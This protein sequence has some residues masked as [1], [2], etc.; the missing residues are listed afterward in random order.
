M[1]EVQ[2]ISM[3][4]KTEAQYALVLAQTGDLALIGAQIGRMVET[5]SSNMILCMY[6]I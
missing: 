2:G 6:I 1:M 3:D 5:G 4:L